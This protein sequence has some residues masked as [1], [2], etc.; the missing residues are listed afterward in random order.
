MA[1]SMASSI[2]CELG[3]NAGELLSEFSAGVRN[4]VSPRGLTTHN[5]SAGRLGVFG[6]EV[7]HII[8]DTVAKGMTDFPHTV[9]SG[10]QAVP[11][12]CG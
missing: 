5:G 2:V 7:V 4:S 8:A 10:D 9:E 11:A 12:V 6:Q 3:L 1:R